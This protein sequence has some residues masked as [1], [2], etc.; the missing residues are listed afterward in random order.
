MVDVVIIGAGIV[1]CAS[2]LSLARRGAG[3]T[4][5]ERSTFAEDAASSAAAGILGGQLE[6]H[7]NAA[8]QGLCIASRSRYGD[9]LSQLGG[10]VGYRRSGSMRVAFDAAAAAELEQEV[11]AQR[12]DGL[13]ATMLHAA[14]VRE[15]EPALSA[16]VVAAAQ[17][18]GDA[19]IDPPRLLMATR[20]AA[21][22]A[23][24]VLR[25][26]AH[27]QR[28]LLDDVGVVLE[29]GEQ[30]FADVVVDCAGSWASLIGALPELGFA[31]DVVRP[32]RGQMLELTAEGPLF[33]HV[34]DGPTAYLSPRS[35]GRV[36]VGST[37]EMVGF[38]RAVTAGATQ[39]LLA[40]ALRL[41]PALAS[42]RLSDSWCGFRALTDDA[43]PAI[44]KIADRVLV[45]TGHFR[46]GVLLAPITADIVTSLVYDEPSPIDLE[47]FQPRRFAK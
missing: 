19:V 43:L 28:L 17:Y 21:E 32:A 44:G 4:M 5:L 7:P 8:M 36:L 22:E 47:P 34:L 41:V 10:D 3:V 13:D 25:T 16:E 1:G 23:G 46:N 38:E 27:V 9:W 29:G 11:L 35:D 40:G 33:S 18:V 39:Q 15:V 45:A 2:A 12:H 31:E 20:R 6:R 37:V 26:G 42:A 24:A 30:V 14:H